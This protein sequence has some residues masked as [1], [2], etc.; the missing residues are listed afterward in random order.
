LI[1]EIDLTMALSSMT[2]FAQ[3]SGAMDGLSW[4]W[5]AR[6]VNGKGLDMR[7]R[8]PPGREALE[9]AVRI[10]VAQAVKRGNVQVTLTVT[11]SAQQGSVMVNKD[12]L[13]QVVMLAEDMRKRLGGPPLQAE[14]LLGLRGVLDIAHT[15]PETD[16]LE[17]QS[18]AMEVSLAEAISGMLAM[19]R[20]EG[21]RL[22]AFLEAQLARIEALAEDARQHPAR[23][24]EAVRRRL[25]EQI[26]RII[27]TAEGLDPARLHQE[28]VLIATR[29]DIQEEIDRLTAHVAAARGLM[30]SPEPAGRKLEFL[31]QELNRESNTLCSKSQD[32]SLT[33]IGLEL[34]SV[35]DQLREQVLN[36][37]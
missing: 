25:S 23:A 7:V 37:E 11:D 36:I 9:P 8:L 3:A 5:E 18:T 10:A 6:S 28:A 19:R 15:E 12:V 32:A 31:A 2:G 33:G 22:A 34:K 20:A 26:A 17:A 4:Q 24:P 16:R 27:E 13:E 30:A 35:V 29:A 14:A 21:E 1:R